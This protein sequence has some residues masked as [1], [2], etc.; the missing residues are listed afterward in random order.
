MK[1]R[2]PVKAIVKTIDGII[3]EALIEVDELSKSDVVMLGTKMYMVTSVAK[4]QIKLEEFVSFG[5]ITP[6]IGKEINGR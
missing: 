5:E 4:F 6:I 1:F 2:K 3:K